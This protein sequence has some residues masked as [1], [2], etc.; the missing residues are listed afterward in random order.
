[1]SAG[2]PLTVRVAKDEIRSAVNLISPACSGLTDLKNRLWDLP[3]TRSTHEVLYQKVLHSYFVCLHLVQH[4]HHSNTASYRMLQFLTLLLISLFQSPT[5][6]SNLDV[7]PR[8]DSA[9][10]PVP[11]TINIHLVDLT[12]EVH[13]LTLHRVNVLQ[14]LDDV[15][16]PSWMAWMDSQCK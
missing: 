11:P 10:I 7:V 3:V 8:A 15:D 2:L 14:L 12:Q 13:R 4:Q 9:V 6:V 1:M 16:V 5:I